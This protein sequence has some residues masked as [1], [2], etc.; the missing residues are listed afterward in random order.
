[1]IRAGR[2]YLIGVCC[3]VLGLV[4][5]GGSALAQTGLAQTGLAQTGFAQTGFAQTGLAQSGTSPSAN[6]PGPADP[7]DPA[8]ALGPGLWR[9][10]PGDTDARSVVYLFANLHILD[11]AA[12]APDWRS[13]AIIGALENARTVWLEADMTSAEA[14]ETARKALE[15]EGDNPPG[16]TLSARLGD[17]ANLLTP[18]AIAIRAP[19]SALEPMR[20]WKAHIVINLEMLRQ[21]GLLPEA[22]PGTVLRAR[23]RDNDQR[24]D[25]LETS[26][27][28]FAVLTDLDERTEA[29]LLEAT[30]RTF[31]ETRDGLPA[32]EAAWRAGDMAA[33]DA[34][35]NAPLRAAAPLAYE[36]LVV[37]RNQRWAAQIQAIAGDRGDSFVILGARHLAGPDSVIAMLREAGHAVSRVSPE[38]P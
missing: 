29:S 11:E 35:M 1:M 30:L 9:I 6:A 19:V 16:T 18:V 4:G 38:A 31:E 21:S 23:A 33:I 27:A 13:P 12:D 37:E 3:A 36:A 28:Q 14:S 26:A 25:F 17:D 24:I 8:E 10:E 20:P 7:A 5:G 15:E 2:F 34:L 22:D 32:L